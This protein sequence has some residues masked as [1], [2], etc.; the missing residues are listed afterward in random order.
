MERLGGGRHPLVV[1]DY[2]HTPDALAQVLT[3]MRPAVRDGGHLVCVFGCGGDRDRGKR[4]P[5][6]AVAGALADRVIVTNDNPRGEDPQAIAG[7]IA[8]GLS[9]GAG[10]LDRRARSARAIEQALA[11]ARAG[12]VV[13]VAGKGHE[14]YQETNGERTPFSDVRCVAGVLARRRDE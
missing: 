1:V 14:D 2:A 10:A 4:A 11:D 13:V 7:A 12:D 6:G 9:R 8:E 5:M 3:A